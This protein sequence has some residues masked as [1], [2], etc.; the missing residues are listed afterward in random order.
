MTLRLPRT[1]EQV[2]IKLKGA[3]NSLDVI[4]SEGTAV[5]YNG[6]GFPLGW[7]NKGPAEDGLE[8]GEPGYRVILEGAFSFVD[9]DDGPA[10]EGGWSEPLPPAEDPDGARTSASF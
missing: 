4:V 5:R 8:D 7:V 2:T 3:F 9:I 1:A 6:P 10:P